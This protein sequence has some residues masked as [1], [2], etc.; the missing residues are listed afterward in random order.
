MLRKSLFL[1]ALLV[2]ISAN[3]FLA[4]ALLFAPLATVSA[5]GQNA[6]DTEAT[7]RKEKAVC[8]Y[9]ANTGTR[10]K[11]KACKTAAQ[12]NAKSEADR[13]A[14]KDMVDRPQ[15]EIRRD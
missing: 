15:I 7:P 4:A 2:R 10:F 3:F 11:T 9:S 13:Q 5:H 14:L 12:W 8:K 6:P 1:E